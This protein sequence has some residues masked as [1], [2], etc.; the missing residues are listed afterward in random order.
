[1]PVWF[2]PSTD[3]LETFIPEPEWVRRGDT[4]DDDDGG[5]EDS[6]DGL[7]N[8]D[9]DFFDSAAHDFGNTS[10]SFNDDMHY[11]DT[12]GDLIDLGAR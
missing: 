12:F 4:S 2:P 7:L 11:F 5:A 9:E 6:L 1:M 10:M 3:R 8:D